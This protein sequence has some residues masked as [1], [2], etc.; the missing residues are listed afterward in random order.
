MVAPAAPPAVAP[1]VL[2]ATV[3]VIAVHPGMQPAAAGQQT[4]SPAAHFRSGTR[5]LHDQ[6]IVTITTRGETDH[7]VGQGDV[8]KRMFGIQLYD[9][10]D[11]LASA[12]RR[13]TVAE[14]LALGARRLQPVIHA[15]VVL[16]QACHEFVNRP[17]LEAG[18]VPGFQP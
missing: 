4:H 17:A 2:P 5:P 14:H 11:R 3:V 13:P 9:A 15:G 12:V 8:G 7:V 16:R 10:T 18:R 6:R 1:A